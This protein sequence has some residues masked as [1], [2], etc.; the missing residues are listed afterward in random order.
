MQK[1]PSPKCSRNKI[2]LISELG[3][4]KTLWNTAY[5][6]KT[7]TAPQRPIVLIR[8]VEEEQALS[9]SPDTRLLSFE[10]KK[11]MQSMQVRPMLLLLILRYIILR[12]RKWLSTRFSAWRLLSLHTLCKFRVGYW[13]VWW[14]E[15]ELQQ[16]A[17][18][19]VKFRRKFRAYYL[20]G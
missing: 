7:F 18:D 15:T 13:K 10:S 9:D 3:F 14:R 2:L 20:K 16:A 4:K 11:R 1:C 6:L 17:A 12:I 5:Q 19:T 8:V